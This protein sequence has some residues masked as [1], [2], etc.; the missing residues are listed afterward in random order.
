MYHCR[1]RGDVRRGVAA[2]AAPSKPLTGFGGGISISDAS[3]LKSSKRLSVDPDV[4]TASDELKKVR[5]TKMVCTIGPTSCS[6]ENLFRLADE[7]M[8]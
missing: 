6:R 7:V 8:I 3:M 2:E 4:V 1:D 5:K